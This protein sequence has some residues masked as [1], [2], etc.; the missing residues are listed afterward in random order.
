MRTETPGRGFG[1]GPGRVAPA[2]EEIR[3]QLRGILATSV[4]HGSKRCQQFLEHVCE[5]ALSG[6]AGAL[7]ERMI[8]IEVFGRQ[9]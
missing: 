6:R 9:P 3:Q 5:K 2:G 1:D 8:A 4:F 7:K